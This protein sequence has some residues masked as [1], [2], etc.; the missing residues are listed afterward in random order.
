VT[1]G[2]LGWLWARYL[3]TRAGLNGGGMSVAERRT[4]E[5]ELKGLRDRLVVNYSPLVKYVAGRVSARMSGPLDGE[6]VLSWGIIGLLDAIETYDPGRRTKFESYAISKIRWSILDE[7]RRADPLTRRVR[8]WA[9]EVE[10]ARGELAQRLKRAPTEEE[11]ARKLGVEIAEHRAF[12]ERYRRAQVGSLEARLE[13]EGNPGGELHGLVADNRAADP[14]SAAETAE[15]RARLV[16]AIKAL[17]EQ[18]RVVTTFYFYEGLTL[19]EIGGA[20]NLTEG[21]ISQILHQ[22]LAKL[23][24]MLSEGLEVP[25]G[26]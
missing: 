7:L 6:D 1:R 21:R 26:R 24:E 25:G 2:T 16:E 18:E 19:R 15:L 17:G 8:R 23:K 12:L 10:L 11:V 13:Y 20:L 3:E 22:A 14:A 5:R 4:A 9:R